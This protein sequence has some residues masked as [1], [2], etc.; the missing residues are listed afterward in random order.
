MPTDGGEAEGL[1]GELDNRPRAPIH[2][3]LLDRMRP[4]RP[5]STPLLVDRWFA[6]IK[7]EKPD[8]L[9]VLIDVHTKERKPVP[10]P[11]GKLLRAVVVE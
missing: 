3:G 11:Q 6:T 10:L 4:V 1:A 9:L 7:Y 2:R 8:S 5:A